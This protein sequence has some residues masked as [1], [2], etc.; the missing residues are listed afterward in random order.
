ME[1]KQYTFTVYARVM[2]V[3]VVT[4][5]SLEDAEEKCSNQDYD[6]IIDQ[7]ES[8]IDWDTLNIEED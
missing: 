3:G 4:A 1:E 6:D 2:Y 8:E 7:C 5:D